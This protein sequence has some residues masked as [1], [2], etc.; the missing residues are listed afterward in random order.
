[1]SILKP[2][3]EEFSTLRAPT[4]LE[5]QGRAS[6][7]AVWRRSRGEA[8]EL[9]A[10]EEDDAVERHGRW[11]LDLQAPVELSGCDLFGEGRLLVEACVWLDPT[12][13]HHQAG[14]PRGGARHDGRPS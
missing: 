12:A 9:R 8:L 4:A 11:C 3:F 5:Q 7:S 14:G 13:L 2:G 1:M 6:G 10:E